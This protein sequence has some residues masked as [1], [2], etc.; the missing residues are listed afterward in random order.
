MG[1][2]EIALRMKSVRAGVRVTFALAVAASAYLLATPHGPYRLLLALMPILAA[3]DGAA[4][5]VFAERIAR[6]QRRYAVFVSAWNLGH[7]AIAV[8]ACLL[9]GGIESPFRAIFFISVAFAALSLPPR[10]VALIAIAD[11]AGMVLVAAI[12]GR[13]QAGLIFVLPA[14][15]AI[16]AL[17]TSIANARARDIAELR[18]AKEGMLHRVARLIEYRDNETGEHT[19]RMSAYC[20]VIARRL[21]WAEDDAQALQLA[22]TMHDVGKVAVPDA[23]L[24]K[25]GPLAAAERAVM[26]RHTLVGH[27]ML[28]GSRSGLIELAATIALT[29]HERVDGRGYPHGLAGDDIPL[30][31][32][33]VAVADVFDA[34]TSDRVYRSAMSV[35]EGLR[36]LTDGRGTQFDEAVLDAF[37]HGL[38]EILA[39]RART[40]IDAQPAPPLAA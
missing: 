15:A 3:L 35:S 1:S 14:L 38:G 12:D 17:G 29:H 8:A 13:W 40:V 28:S 2:S 21:G 34:L 20:G 7:S 9:D 25:P 36:I 37:E 22:A 39:I 16:A 4:I 30:A 19:E 23:V 11:V 33:I 24:L 26:E 32:R 31:G 10:P 27:E 5:A 18:L 6:T